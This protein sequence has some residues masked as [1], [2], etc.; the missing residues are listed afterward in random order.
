MI[1][2]S[3]IAPVHLQKAFGIV[4][5]LFFSLSLFATGALSGG[6]FDGTGCLHCNLQGQLPFA[7][8]GTA[9]MSHGCPNGSCD[10]ENSTTPGE[11]PN[12]IAANIVDNPNVVGY[13]VRAADDFADTRF[14]RRFI[15]LPAFTEPFPTPP[16]YLLNR[17][18]LC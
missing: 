8:A 18:L 4:L 7:R 16:V 2:K 10:F 12:T 14:S 11:L 3:N 1:L 17:S 5:V 15:P 13:A 6:C 9:P